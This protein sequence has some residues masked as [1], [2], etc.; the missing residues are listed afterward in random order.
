MGTLISNLKTLLTKKGYYVIH[1][2]YLLDDKLQQITGNLR[3]LDV[4]N[5][6]SCKYIY[7]LACPSM[8]NVCMVTNKVPSCANIWYKVP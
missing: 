8:I 3:I 5:S 1:L 6:Q 7:R 4:V 2:P